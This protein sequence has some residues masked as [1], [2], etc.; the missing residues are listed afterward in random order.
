M[1]FVRKLASKQQEGDNRK[2]ISSATLFELSLKLTRGNC[3]F[4]MLF[5]TVGFSKD[6]KGS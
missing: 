1:I 3:C 2:I 4:S 6:V 5:L